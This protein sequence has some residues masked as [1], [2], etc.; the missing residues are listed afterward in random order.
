MRNHTHYLLVSSFSRSMAP[1]SKT[2]N[3]LLTSLFYPFK[4]KLQ[5]A[6]KPRWLFSKDLRGVVATVADPDK[7]VHK[8]GDGIG[9]AIGEFVNKKRECEEQVC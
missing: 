6:L 2:K 8:H 1:K 4:S 3:L 7:F 5:T 9:N